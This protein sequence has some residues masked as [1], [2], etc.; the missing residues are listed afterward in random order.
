MQ[1]VRAWQA[2][3]DCLNR[4]SVVADPLSLLSCSQDGTVRLWS[5]DGDQWGLIDT[6]TSFPWCMTG[7]GCVDVAVAVWMWLWLCGCVAVWLCGCGD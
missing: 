4:V 2:H 7:C 5:M 3:A 1:L 6:S